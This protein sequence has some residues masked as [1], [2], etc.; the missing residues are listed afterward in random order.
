MEL[1][2]A[3]FNRQVIADQFPI[4]LVIKDECD[5]RRE[6]LLIAYGLSFSCC[7]SYIKDLRKDIPIK[8]VVLTCVFFLLQWD[9]YI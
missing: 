9:L 8:S 5:T 7:D 4:V 6:L 1:A 3:F 2:I